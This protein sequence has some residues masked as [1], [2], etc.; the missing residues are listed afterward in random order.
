MQLLQLV[1]INVYKNGGP[2]STPSKSVKNVHLKLKKNVSKLATT[3]TTVAHSND[4]NW[5]GMILARGGGAMGRDSRAILLTWRR[6][7]GGRSVVSQVIWLTAWPGRNTFRLYR[8]IVH[9]TENARRLVNVAMKDGRRVGG[10]G[11]GGAC[12]L[13][14][15]GRPFGDVTDRRRARIAGWSFKPSKSEPCSVIDL[16]AMCAMQFSPPSPLSALFLPSICRETEQLWRDNSYIATGYA[17]EICIAVSFA[18]NWVCTLSRFIFIFIHQTG[19][20]IYKINDKINDYDA[21]VCTTGVQ[22]Y[23]R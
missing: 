10:G 6:S 7:M 9:Q 8:T 15:P 11:G 1:K 20:V 5:F 18:S 13:T 4:D 2:L 22:Q 17:K 21:T 19:S 16:E 23:W 14:L 12:A 3:T